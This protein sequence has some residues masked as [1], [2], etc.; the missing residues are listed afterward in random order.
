MAL[1]SYQFEMQPNTLYELKAL[2]LSVNSVKD[3]SLEVEGDYV[4][5]YGSYSGEA[6]ISPPNNMSLGIRD[7]I[8]IDSIGNIPRFIYFVGSPTKIIING[9]K[10]LEVM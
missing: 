1:K 4:D 3:Y 2:S 10:P 7:F 5:V 6:P 8:G 9:I